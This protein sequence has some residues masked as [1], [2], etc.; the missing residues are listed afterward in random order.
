[1]TQHVIPT[2]SLL[3]I[4]VFI[5]VSSWLDVLYFFPAIFS[6]DCLTALLKDIEDLHSLGLLLG[7][8][9]GTLKAIEAYY[10]DAEFIT[11]HVITLWLVKD[12]DNPVTYLRDALNTLEKYDISQ[13]LWCLVSLGK[14]STIIRCTVVYCVQELVDFPLFIF[15]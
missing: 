3:A 2:L 13:K 15:R 9:E 12:P 1:M 11:R 5:C 10:E 14:F 7:I 6:I 4:P 8:E